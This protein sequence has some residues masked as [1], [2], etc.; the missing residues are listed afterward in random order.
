MVSHPH[1]RKVLLYALS[2]R[3]PRH[4]APQLVA[5]L[6]APGD[7]SGGTRKPLALRALELIIQPDGLLPSLLQLAID[8]MGELFLGD[9]TFWPHVAEDRLRLHLL[10]EMLIRR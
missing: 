7:Q 1:A 2:P 3:D 4:F 6:L 8:R 10:A 9:S 5:S